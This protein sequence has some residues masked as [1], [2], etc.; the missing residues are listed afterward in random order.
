[1]KPA[2]DPDRSH[3]NNA[4]SAY[5]ARCHSQRLINFWMSDEDAEALRA[6][7][8]ELNTDVSKHL[9]KLIKDDLSQ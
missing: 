9:R 6:R 7:V 2:A 4:S 1:M 3:K 8:R 5:H